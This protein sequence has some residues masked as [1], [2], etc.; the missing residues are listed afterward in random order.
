MS[1]WEIHFASTPS[2]LGPIC[3]SKNDVP[4]LAQAI[5]IEW[6]PRFTRRLGDA[7]FN[8]TTF[9]SKIRLAIPLWPRASFQDKRETVVH[10][11]CHLIVWYKLGQ[12]I[13]PHGP[14]WR[15]AMENCGVQPLR[16]HE[17]DRTDLARRQ[18]RFVLLDCPNQGHEHKCRMGVREFNQIHKGVVMECKKCGLVVKLEA[19]EEEDWTTNA[20]A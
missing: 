10:E 19:V 20:K 13:K 1:D 4:E 3:L 12:F 8:P 11:A 9:Q 15:Q 18:R 14:E 17:V 7:I 5:V 6:N 2:Q 16:T